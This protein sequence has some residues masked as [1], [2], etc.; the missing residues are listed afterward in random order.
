MSTYQ[1][2]TKHP[3]TGRWE[4]ATWIDDYFA[5]HHYGVEFPDG[6]VFDPWQKPLVTD[7]NESEARLINETIYGIA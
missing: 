7:I 3:V 2:F 6:S 1:R 5:R 4:N